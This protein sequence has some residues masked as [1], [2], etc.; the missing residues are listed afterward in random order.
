VYLPGSCFIGLCAD[1]AYRLSGRLEQRWRGA[2]AGTAAQ[3]ATFAVMALGLTL[4]YVDPSGADSHVRLFDTYYY[5]TAPWMVLNGAL[6]G[7]A[8]WAL[9][10]PARTELTTRHR[11]SLP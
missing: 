9:R 4:L 2:L 10:R 5:F 1:L 6:G 11:D 7:F 3:A 8:A